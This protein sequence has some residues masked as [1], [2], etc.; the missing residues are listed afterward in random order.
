MTTAILRNLTA[1]TSEPGL[2]KICVKSARVKSPSLNM[3]L[4]NLE[5]R[6]GEK[7]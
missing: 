5:A 7:R 1:K 6:Q 3:L 2:C 4:V